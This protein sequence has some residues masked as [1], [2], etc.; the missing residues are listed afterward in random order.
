MGPW[1]GLTLPSH[2]P[3]TRAG[4]PVSS[5]LFEIWKLLLGG[6]EGREESER[7]A[8]RL[9]VKERH[10][11]ETECCEPLPRPHPHR[12]IQ[13]LPLPSHLCTVA[14]RYRGEHTDV[15]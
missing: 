11:W 8:E 4:H 5:G 10:R 7:C 6:T 13:T 2:Y 3:A 14:S 12:C 15:F 1:E 9:R